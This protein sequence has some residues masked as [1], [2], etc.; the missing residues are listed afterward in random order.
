MV[1]LDLASLGLGDS[2]FVEVAKKHELKA[3]GGRLVVHYQISDD[4]VRRLEDVMDDVLAMGKKGT[5]RR[6]D[7]K[8][9]IYGNGSVKKSKGQDDGDEA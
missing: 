9:D 3:F 1:W 2:D 7:G 5:Q 6:E 4:G 8:E